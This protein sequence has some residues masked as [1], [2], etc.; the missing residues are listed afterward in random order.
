MYVYVCLCVYA[1]MYVCMYVYVFVCWY[2]CY[3][4]MIAV[5]MYVS[6]GMFY[7]MHACMCSIPTELLVT[8][9]R[10]ENPTNTYINSCK[11]Q[12]V[13]LVLTIMQKLIIMSGHFVQTKPFSFVIMLT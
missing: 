11:R 6:T 10:A 5:C 3:L 8:K 2:V 13:L 9:K 1:C 12:H 4:C 7:V